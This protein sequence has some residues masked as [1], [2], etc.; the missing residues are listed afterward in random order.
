MSET[1]TTHIQPVVDIRNLGRRFGNQ[2][3]L[4]D[5]SFT[6]P[7]GKVCGL[8]G[9]R[10]AGKTTLLRHV[11]GLLKAQTGTV[12]V[13]GEDPSVEPVGILSRIGYV[14]PVDDLPNNFTLKELLW[15]LSE[16][17]PYWDR[18]YAN[19]LTSQFE[20]ELNIRLSE[21]SPEQRAQ[22]Q[23]IAA[24]S[25]KPELLVIDAPAFLQDKD[26]REAYMEETIQTIRDWKGAVVFTSH[27]VGEIERMSDFVVLLERGS[28][29]SICD[30]DDFTKLAPSL[31]S[32]CECES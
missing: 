3:V 20:L 13:L 22:A 32:Q 23:L 21:F 5:V 27:R 26:V 24:V 14:P 11:V 6:V 8:Y 31:P 4:R 7:R 30:V 10:A 25:S 28:V 16:L 18:A 1:A 12:S 9:P 2:C 17:Y 19:Q 29:Q 15:Y